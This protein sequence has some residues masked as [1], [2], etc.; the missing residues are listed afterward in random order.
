[1][2]IRAIKI[3]KIERGSSF[4]PGIRSPVGGSHA[5]W[6]APELFVLEKEAVYH[7]LIALYEVFI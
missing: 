1:M 5:R 2:K 6:S 7:G 4:K 3:C